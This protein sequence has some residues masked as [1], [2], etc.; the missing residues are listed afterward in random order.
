MSSI[1][2][3]AVLAPNWLGDAVMAL[4][5]IADVRSHF[6]GA[7]LRVAARPAVAPLFSLVPGI[8]GVDAL[9][10]NAAEESR[11][12]KAGQFDAA[13]LLPNSFRAAW[14]AKRAG[15]PERWGYRGDGRSWL[16]TRS[17]R[18]PGGPVHQAEY[19]QHL[20]AA[21][22]MPRVAR[23]PCLDVPADV[24][25]S[26]LEL[27]RAHGHDGQAPL[28]VLAPGAA[29]G[30]AKQWIPGHAAALV[31]RLAAERDARCVRIGSKGDAATAAE[32]ASELGPGA[33][34]RTIDLIGRTTLPQLAGILSAA[35]VCISN[36]SGAM[37]LA[38]AVGTRLV[39]IFGPTN[40][41]ETAPFVRA[42]SMSEVLTH[43]VWCRPCM[44]R[45][46]PIDHSCM[47]LITPDRVFTSAARMLDAHATR[48][49]S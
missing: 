40:E 27:L 34:A 7:H 25:S 4:P 21:L 12:L 23:E 22:A 19:Y 33:A 36:D 38:A 46:C 14:L 26:A 39:A 28:I 18:R 3:L 15:I 17:A 42:G 10:G 9:G 32:I 30:T 49:L 44:L 48:R 41:K 1:S 45:E 5:A 16:L 20:T 13:L 35:G 37:H 6:P 2:R 29:Y 24:R 8:D 47:T 43:D 31:T 11:V